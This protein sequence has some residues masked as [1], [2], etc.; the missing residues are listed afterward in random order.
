MKKIGILCLLLL[1]SSIPLVGK[2]KIRLYRTSSPLMYLRVTEVI[3]NARIP[4]NGGG[5]KNAPEGNLFAQISVNFANLTDQPL[6]D[7]GL[8]PVDITISPK[9]LVLIGDNGKGY[10]GLS[11]TKLLRRDLKPF[12]EERAL[13]PGED[14]VATMCFL[15]PKRI[16]IVGVRYSFPGGQILSIDYS[17]KSQIQ[18]DK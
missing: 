2:E 17:D 6:Q 10:S 5:E 16:K 11:A 12:I 9:N 13:K 3:Y 15:V 8:H 4:V 7:Y 14:L 18:P 1:L